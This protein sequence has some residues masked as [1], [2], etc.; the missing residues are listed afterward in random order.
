MVNRFM[1]G[2]S[3]IVLIVVA[4]MLL[5]SH[6][7]AEK[8]P[9]DLLSSARFPMKV[10]YKWIYQYGDKEVS[11]DVLRMEMIDGAAV[12]VVQR[13]IEDS[14]VEFKVSMKDH[15]VYIYQEGKKKFSPPLRQF[16]FFART[17]D[18]WKWK[19][20]VNEKTERHEFTNL[21]VKIITVPAGTYST[22]A[23]RQSNLDSFGQVT[24]WLV[25]GIGVV[26]LSGKTESKPGDGD[27]LHNFEW[28]LK[29]FE[30]TKK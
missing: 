1:P 30:K 16:A 29:R 13:K 2:I 27:G 28:Q 25:D 11:F 21:G 15:G 7:A 10:G 17:G 4:A 3:R 18:I 22:I 9:A 5:C 12:Y 19:G 14:T 8:R 6:A 20:T 23:V 26:K 24:F